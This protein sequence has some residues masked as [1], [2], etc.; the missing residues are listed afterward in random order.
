MVLSVGA[1]S[2]IR[3]RQRCVAAAGGIGGSER[4]VGGAP[5]CTDEG[6][7][8]F[9]VA[10]AFRSSNDQSCQ[11][12]GSSAELHEAIAEPSV[13]GAWRDRAYTKTPWDSSE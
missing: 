4:A 7:E 13:R 2:C 5:G 6:R 10:L 12:D 11:P 1:S 8:S 3:W 9:D